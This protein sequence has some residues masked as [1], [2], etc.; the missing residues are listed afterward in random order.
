MTSQSDVDCA[1][2]QPRSLASGGILALDIVGLL[3]LFFSTM[4]HADAVVGSGTAASCTEAALNAAIAVAG[5]VT[6]DCGTSP[7][8]L[9]IT[10]TKTIAADTSIDGAKLVSFDCR[11]RGFNVNAG[12]VLTL[13][14]LTITNAPASASGGAVFNNHGILNVTNSTFSFNGHSSF[15]AGLGGAIYNIGTLNGTDSTFFANG[16][17]PQRG[18]SGGAIYGG[19][20]NLTR[21]T[22]LGNHS[23][24]GGA[25]FGGGGVITDS[26]FSGNY[27]AYGGAISGSGGEIRSTHFDGNSAT[28]NSNSI[29]GA[30]V[31]SAQLSVVSSTFSNN[32]V[33]GFSGSPPNHAGGAVYNSGTLTVAD[34]TFS[35]NGVGLGGAIYNDCDFATLAVTNSTFSGNGGAGG[36]LFN[37]NMAAVSNSTFTGNGGGAFGGAIYSVGADLTLTNSTLSANGAPLGDGTQGGNIEAF[38][39]TLSNTIIANSTSGANCSAASSIIDGGHNLDSDGTCGIGPATDPMLAPVG[40]ADNGGPTQTLALQTGSPAIN[41]GDE[42]ICAAPPVNN[43]D[44]RG[45]VRPGLGVANCS[46]GAFE[47]TTPGAADCCQCPAICTVPT[48]GSCRECA[49]VVGASCQGGSACLRHTPTPPPTP[50]VTP[51]GAPTDTATP[52]GTPTPTP[53]NTPSATDTPR[54]IPT[55]TPTSSVT[56]TPSG[57]C[58]ASPQIGCQQ[59]RRAGLSINGATHRLGATWSG[60]SALPVVAGFGDPVNGSTGYRLCIY[61]TGG[62]GTSLA[63]GAG[64]PAGGTCGRRQCWKRLRDTFSYLNIAGNPDG[65]RRVSLRAPVGNTAAAIAVTG[66]G[67]NLRVPASTDGIFLLREFPAVIVQLQRGDSPDCW[68]AVFTT[69]AMRDTRWA[70]ADTVR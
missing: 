40:L 50:T 13:S 48:A 46:I 26:S 53:T 34:S 52:T 15:G 54:A 17:D 64:V 21:C 4:A 32:G 33:G 35:N 51:T 8:T 7:V 12:I 30:I 67:A 24:N 5:S 45:L 68:E 14:N 11:T 36:A 47:Y 25:I 59:A 9:T 31:N 20:I 60:N 29:G 16:N 66:R 63:F 69:P 18:G 37:C 6:F 22:F 57:G 41:G 55:P 19:G 61:D 3:V 70:F 43:L 2:R 1:I 44:Q 39:A 56:P 23:R 28:V 58:A 42:T 49:V 27:A 10:S 65:I 38:T 62:G